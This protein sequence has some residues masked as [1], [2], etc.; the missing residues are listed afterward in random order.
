MPLVHLA[1]QLQNSI[2]LFSIQL[3][4]HI[5]VCFV[6]FSLL[7][8]VS[9]PSFTFIHLFIFLFIGLHGLLRVSLKSTCW[10][11]SYTVRHITIRS[12]KSQV[13]LQVSN[14][15]DTQLWKTN[16][17]WN[18]FARRALV[19]TVL[20]SYSF[21]KLSYSNYLFRAL[22]MIVCFAAMDWL[23]ESDSVH[24]IVLFFFFSFLLTD[25]FEIKIV[26]SDRK[27]P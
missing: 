19:L 8:A 5:T 1:W 13:R 7:F 18:Y 24:L 3:I 21:L 26:G 25:V 16:I 6:S 11:L 2:K 27:I 14:F 4:I 12:V 10:R 9:S 20:K 17:I 15:F 22:E 23:V